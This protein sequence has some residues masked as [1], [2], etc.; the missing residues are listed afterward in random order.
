MRVVASLALKRGRLC[1]QR[2]Q[3]HPTP[4]LLPGKSHGRRSLVGCSPWGRSESDTTE[5]FHFHF[6]LSWLE[7]EMRLSSSSSK[8]H[9]YIYTHI[10]YYFTLQSTFYC[11]SQGPFSIYFRYLNTCWG[12]FIAGSYCNFVSKD[13]QTAC[14]Y[15]Q[16][17]LH[18]FVATSLEYGPWLAVKSCV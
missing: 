7:K 12:P 10:S 14:S 4:V 8:M 1:A 3:W 2:R 9:I 11:F 15:L 6:S 13:A 17:A 16:I 18:P 5:R